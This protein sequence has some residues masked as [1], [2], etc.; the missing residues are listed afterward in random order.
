MKIIGVEFVDFCTI[1]L[2]LNWVLVLSLAILTYIGIR[3]LKKIRRAAGQKSV[4]VDEMV[5]GI[6]G[7]TIKLKYNRKDQEIAYKLWVELNTRK[8]GLPF[9]TENDVIDEVYNSWYRFFEIAREL[10][11]GIPVSRLEH[12]TEL[13]ELTTN[14]LNQGLRP[15]LTTWQAKYKKWYSYAREQDS[16]RSPQAIQRDFPEYHEL[17]ADLIETNKRMIEYKD[18]MKI[19]AFSNK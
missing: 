12:S 9:D 7:S 5:L 13:I 3:V 16:E 2:S 10:L 18:L 11:K 14:V 6:G 17:V 4:D 15:H 1:A 19:I 8:I